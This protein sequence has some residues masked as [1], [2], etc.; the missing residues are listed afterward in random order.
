MK[1][2]KKWNNKYIEDCGCVQSDDAVSFYKAFRNFL[3]RS[4]PD[5]E[6]IGFKPNHYA[7]SGFIKRDDKFIYVSHSINRSKCR[8]DFSDSGCMSGVLYR[9]AKDEH[10]FH[11]GT[12]HFT[13]MY[14]LVD[15]INWLFEQMQ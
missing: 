8:V 3:K 14:K 6:I 11:G 13:S 4:F 10:D 12:N 7:A 1:T 15:D 9:T 5:A 2:F